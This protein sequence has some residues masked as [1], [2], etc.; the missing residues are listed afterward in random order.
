MQSTEQLHTTEH[1]STIYNNRANR[2]NSGEL[3]IASR[4]K[5]LS[6]SQFPAAL[7]NCLLAGHH[8]P[9]RPKG[10]KRLFLRKPRCTLTSK[11]LKND[12]RTSMELLIWNLIHSV[13]IKVLNAIST[14]LG[15][16]GS[17]TSMAQQEMNAGL[18]FLVSSL[19][20]LEKEPWCSGSLLPPATTKEL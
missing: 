16:L 3:S 18:V 11:H 9:A 17:N 6:H 13:L 15:T 12:N 2:A 4:R 7:G 1:R 8:T 10:S 14:A 19:H 20:F 5:L